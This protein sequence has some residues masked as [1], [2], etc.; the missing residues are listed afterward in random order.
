MRLP[1][2][3]IV[4]MVLGELDKPTAPLAA[5]VHVVYDHCERL[6]LELLPPGELG[7]GEF[8]V[9]AMKTTVS[10]TCRMRE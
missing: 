5:D 3:V 1:V 4:E 9:N 7:L 6:L 2:A 8:A 10:M